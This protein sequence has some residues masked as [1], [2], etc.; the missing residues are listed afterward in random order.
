MTRL[1]F[2]AQPL[3]AFV[4]DEPAASCIEAR[5]RSTEADRP[6]LIAAAN[7]CEFLYVV[8]RLT[9]AASAARAA[10]LLQ[11]AGLS[12]VS[13]DAELATFAAELKA[14]HRLG[15]G[16]AF[17]AALAVAL[18]APLVTGDSDFLA[19]A[20]DGKRRQEAEL[21]GLVSACH[22]CQLFKRSLSES[23]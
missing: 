3:V 22:S 21:V 18:S 13:V 14:R 17:A 4:L 8:R 1:V 19:L 11:T 5:L 2:D 12:V 15:L 6:G 9:D 10:S 16:D 23:A 7:W 20:D